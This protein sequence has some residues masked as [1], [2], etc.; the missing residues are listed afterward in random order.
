MAVGSI[1]SRGEAAPFDAGPRARLRRRLI[2]CD[3]PLHCRVL[4][5]APAPF[6]LQGRVA[7]DRAVGDGRASIAPPGAARGVQ[8]RLT[9]V[10]ALAR[11]C[12]GNGRRSG[13]RAR[14]CA[15]PSSDAGPRR[16]VSGQRG[17][18]HLGSCART[19]RS[20]V[21]DRFTPR[22]ACS[23]PCSATVAHLVLVQRILVR[24]EAG[25]FPLPRRTGVRGTDQ[26]PPIRSCATRAT[27]KP[28]VNDESNRVPCRIDPINLTAARRTDRN[29][30]I[31][32][33]SPRSSSPQGRGRA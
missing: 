33:V 32:A 18:K 5:P 12:R 25:E 24:I 30:W 8:S 21:K 23:L 20:I 11:T 17:R 26:A 31:E 6:P 4:Q 14:P 22:G 9:D 3:R 10:P 29:R 1:A 28:V 7:P 13:T 16:S 27:V 2:P 19:T 15:R